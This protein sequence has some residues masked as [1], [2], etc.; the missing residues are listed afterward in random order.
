MMTLEHISI[1]SEGSALSM[2]IKI[3]LEEV[4]LLDMIPLPLTRSHFSHFQLVPALLPLSASSAPNI[5]SF[6]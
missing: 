3:S 4:C 6:N 1:S 2:K 5:C